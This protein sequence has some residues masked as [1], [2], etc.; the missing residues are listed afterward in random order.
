MN[1][2]LCKPERAALEKH[3]EVKKGEWAISTGLQL[4][5]A[6]IDGK[7]TGNQ[8]SIQDLSK[9]SFTMRV[10]Y[11]YARCAAFEDNRLGD[12]DTQDALLI[13][14]Q[15][16]TTDEHNDCMTVL[17]PPR[18]RLTVPKQHFRFWMAQSESQRGQLAD[19]IAHLKPGYDLPLYLSK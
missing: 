9:F 12:F 8:Q 16:I 1:V 15:A 7:M 19:L 3:Q 11:T 6:L 13:P 17:I 18:R 14:L 4:Y 10:L 2:K 5:K